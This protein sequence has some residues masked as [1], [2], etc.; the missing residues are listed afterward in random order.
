MTE[1]A[2]QSR[3]EADEARVALAGERWRARSRRVKLYRRV[4]PIIILVLAGGALT[5]TVFRTVMSGVERK[6]SQSNEVRLDKP[7]F[8]GQDSQGRAF[9]VGAQG[10]VRDAATGQFRLVG[11]ALKLNLGGRKVTELTAGGGTYNEQARTVTLGPDVKISDGG[12]GFVLTTPEAVVNTD[13]GVI[14]GSKGVQGAGPLG[15]INASSYAIYDQG[16][17]VVFDGQGDKKISGTIN[18]SGSGG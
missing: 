13:T 7:L 17:R 1:P 16:Q 11:P 12:T 18:P 3:I 4:L 9:T 6:A 8:H 5:W 10:A 14:T 15:T 2:D